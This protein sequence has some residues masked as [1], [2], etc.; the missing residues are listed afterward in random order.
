MPKPEKP[1]RL[2]RHSGTG[3]RGLPKKEGAGKFGWGKPGTGEDGPSSLDEDD[4]NYASDEEVET[5]KNVVFSKVDVDSPVQVVLQEFYVSGEESEAV[6]SFKEIVPLEAHAQF[7][8]KLLIF[9][10]ERYAFEREHASRLL[11]ALYDKALSG[12]EIC[13]GLQAALDAVDDF[14]LDIRDG[15]DMLAKF[16][17]RA[18]VDEVVPPAFLKNA[19]AESDKAREVLS[20]ANG[21]IS[22]RH[23]SE[24]LSHIWGPGDLTSVKRLKEEVSTIIGEYISNDDQ[25]EAYNSVRNL[26]APSFHPQ[27]VKQAVRMALEQPNHSAKIAQLLKFFS[28]TGL[29]SSD[30]ISKGLQLVFALKDDIKLDVPNAE[31]LLAQFVEKGKAEKWIASDFTA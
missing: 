31:T 15:V 11:S 4:P 8:K 21:L 12:T 23:G 20:L 10:M 25:K 29:I 18:I 19:L 14:T 2:D 13:D 1:E 5:S 30:H 17:A 24:R 3:L 22:E 6:R 16:I 9:A 27:L 28:S 26:G 7:V